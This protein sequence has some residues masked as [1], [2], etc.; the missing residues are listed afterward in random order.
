MA[1][2]GKTATASQAVETDRGAYRC[3]IASTL[4]DTPHGPRPVE[5]LQAG[6][7]VSTLDHGSQPVAWVWNG[8]QPLKGVAPG[9]RPVLICAGALAPGLPARDL[10]LSPHHR[11]LV[12]EAAQ[13]TQRF[14]QPALAAAQALTEEP[15]VRVMMGRRAIHW[16]NFA[17]ERHQVVCANGVFTESLLIEAKALALMTGAER[18]QIARAFPGRSGAFLNGP[19]ARPLLDITDAGQGLAA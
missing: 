9:Q 6:D 2:G 5:A 7:M 12:G 19:P 3:F 17:C 11:V 1:F 13:I 18:R 4:I 15:G 14:G 8:R 10:I 16:F